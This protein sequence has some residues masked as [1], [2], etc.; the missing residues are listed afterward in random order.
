MDFAD[1]SSSMTVWHFYFACVNLNSR[2]YGSLNQISLSLFRNTTN[3]MVHMSHDVEVLG[4]SVIWA[5]GRVH[6]S[7]RLSHHWQWSR[8]AQERGV[9]TGPHAAPLPTVPVKWSLN[10]AF[11]TQNHPINIYGGLTVVPKCQHDYSLHVI[12]NSIE[13]TENW[14][15]RATRK[16]TWNT[17]LIYLCNSLS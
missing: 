17:K 8:P 3:H 10:I 2:F 4:V 14:A 9:A 12:F 5:E 6:V 16:L 13:A 1:H 7:R 15:I 11:M